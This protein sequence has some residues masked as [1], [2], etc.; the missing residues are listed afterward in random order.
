MGKTLVIA[1]KP[2]VGRDLAK[3]LPGSFQ[4]GK[5][6][7]ERSARWMEG[8]D[9]V[10]TWA[11]GHLVQLAEPDAYDKKFKRWKME[12]LPIV[13][14]E[15]QLVVRDDQSKK[16]MAVIKNLLKRPDIDDVINACDA[17]REG[18]L[19]FQW[20]FKAGGGTQ[21][22]SLGDGAW[23]IARRYGAD[24]LKA[25]TEISGTLATLENLE[26]EFEIA[27]RRVEVAQLG[28]KQAGMLFKAGL[29]T[30]LEVIN[31]QRNAISS[32]LNLVS[33]QQQLVLARVELY[34]ALGGGWRS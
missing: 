23:G 18:E 30:Y 15:F 19:I 14:E 9:H 16:Q 5:P 1:E 32:E 28:T 2:S 13:P 31:A 20:V 24:V 8:P 17:G 33:V 3:V 27:E 10:I 12:D 11:I 4:V 7:G 29:A 25:V 6:T 26:Q 21:P 34:R 22:L